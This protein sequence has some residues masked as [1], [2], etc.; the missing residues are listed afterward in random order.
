MLVVQNK[1]L[2][3]VLDLSHHGDTKRLDFVLQVQYLLFLRHRALVRLFGRRLQT[4][5]QVL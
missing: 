2:V 3:F 5:Y 4:R 1:A